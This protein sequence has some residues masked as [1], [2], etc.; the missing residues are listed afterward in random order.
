Q[1]QREM[2]TRYATSQRHPKVPTG[3]LELD[4]AYRDAGDRLERLVKALAPAEG[5]GLQDLPVDELVAKLQAL[6]DSE[7]A[8]HVLPERTLVL[9][10]LRE[11][12]LGDLLEDLAAREVGPDE[13]AAELDLAWWQSALEAMISGDEYL[14]MSD[15]AS[16]RKL[17]AEYRL[18]DNTHIAS[19]ASRLRWQLAQ[20]WK[21]AL[22]DHR[23][24]SRELRMMLK[25][26][27]P[28]VADLAGLGVGLVNALVPV[29]VGS[30]LLIPAA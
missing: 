15:G 30:P 17:E 11:Q 5:T 6:V 7:D 20:R 9:E 2:W 1:Q 8:L 23:A 14:A 18:A 29:W 12:G 25:D 13:V 27:E 16:L 22:A 21:A 26:G 28:T 24:A 19:G 4:K 3:L 10:Q